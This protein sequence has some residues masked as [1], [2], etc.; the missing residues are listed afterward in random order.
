MCNKEGSILWVPSPPF[1]PVSSGCRK[2]DCKCYDEV[3]Q[4]ERLVETV[5]MSN[6]RHGRRW[7]RERTRRDGRWNWRPECHEETGKADGGRMYIQE[8]VGRAEN[9]TVYPG[10]ERSDTTLVDDGYLTSRSTPLFSV[11][12]RRVSLVVLRSTVCRLL[13][14]RGSRK[15]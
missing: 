10:R 9:I 12:T 6:E 4:W 3:S 1:E 14:I 7:K 8:T 2:L 13:Q 15:L 5:W 11:T